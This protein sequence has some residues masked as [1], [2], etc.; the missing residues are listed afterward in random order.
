M[1]LEHFFEPDV[2]VVVVIWIDHDEPVVPSLNTRL[3]ALAADRHLQGRSAVGQLR[4][5]RNPVVGTCDVAALRDID[6]SQCCAASG[7]NRL[8]NGGHHDVQPFTVCAVGHV[9]GTDVLVPNG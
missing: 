8:T 7:D 2:H 1:T 3:V 5:V 9:G 6:T 4:S